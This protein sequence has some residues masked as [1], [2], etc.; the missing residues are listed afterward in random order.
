MNS[1]DEKAAAVNSLGIIAIHAP[2][3]MA[4]K[5]KEILESMEKL[6]HY[7]HENVKFHVSKAYNDIVLGMMRANGLLTEEDKFEWTAGS[8]AGCV[9]PVDVMQMLNQIVFPYMY[10]LFDQ[11]D[12]KEGTELK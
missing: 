10:A 1:V 11:E 6:H 7:F 5:R 12:N 8:P 9:L 2:K 3:L 4:G